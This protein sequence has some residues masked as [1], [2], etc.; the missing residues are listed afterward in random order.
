MS[1][2][3]EMLMLCSGTGILEI[4]CAPSP[5]I[6]TVSPRPTSQARKEKPGREPSSVF[7][8]AYPRVRPLAFMIEIIRIKG[9]EMMT[10]AVTYAVHGEELASSARE[11][12]VLHHLTSN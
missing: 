10:P 3:G 4:Q 12:H 11:Q 6:R 9:L 5:T 7:L 1:F 2:D 8:Q